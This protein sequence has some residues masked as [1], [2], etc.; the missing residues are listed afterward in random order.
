METQTFRGNIGGELELT[1]TSKGTPVAK[2]RLA[3][4]DRYQVNGEWKD[5]ETVWI[6]VEAWRQLALN[7]KESLPSGAAVIVVG[8]WKASVYEQDGQIRRFQYVVADSIGVDLA[9]S[10]ANN[11]QR[12]KKADAQPAQKK[13]GEV[14]ASNPFEED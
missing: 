14:E 4:N 13:T 12:T 2:F 1:E 6:N 3:C 7:A 9:Y 11:V 5:A 10:T 8:K